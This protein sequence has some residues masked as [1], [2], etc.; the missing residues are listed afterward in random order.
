MPISAIDA[1]PLAFQHTKQ[2]LFQP[3]RLGQWSKLALVGLLAGELGS[4]GGFHSSSF[5]FPKH[6]HSSPH[7]LPPELA[8]LHPAAIVALIALFVFAVLTFVIVMMYINS[9]MRFILFDS[10]VAKECRIRLG[11]SNRQTEGWRYFLWQVLYFMAGFAGFSLLVIVPAMFA[12]LVGWLSQPKEHILPLV[13]GGVFL[14]FL[15]VIFFV[16]MATI[17]VLTKDFV[18]PQMAI[19]RISAFE[20]WRRLWYMMKAEAGAYAAY[21]G[22]KILMAVGAGILVAIATVILGLIIAVPT[23]G[24]SIVAIL[25]G[26]SAGLTWNVYT[27]TVAVVVGLI[28][29]AIFFYLVALISV[30]VI[31]F[32]PAYAIYFFAARYPGLETL[33]HGTPSPIPPMGAAFGLPG[34]T[35]PLPPAAAPIG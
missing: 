10:I 7:I 18:I 2:Q 33:L 20:A 4:G 30:P 24:L 25:T 22:M 17:F 13:L 3:F 23:I 8:G 35:P 34:E 6:P 15:L 14:F 27:I 21:I 28:L 26:K 11:W 31:V 12:F 29:L 32:F 9:V 19:E 1:I 5:N 16:T